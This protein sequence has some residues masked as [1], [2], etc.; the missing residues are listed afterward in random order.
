[1]LKQCLD[2]AQAGYGQAL[3]ITGESGIG[4]SR[5]VAQTKTWANQMGLRVFHGLS[6]GSTSLP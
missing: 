4:K 1:M 2:E 3:L 6:F 5:L